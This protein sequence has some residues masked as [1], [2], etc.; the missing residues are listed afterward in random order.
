MRRE[1]GIKVTKSNEELNEIVEGLPRRTEVREGERS[2][3]RKDVIEDLRER[4][5]Q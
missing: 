1:V 4:H 2:G 5:L 3:K